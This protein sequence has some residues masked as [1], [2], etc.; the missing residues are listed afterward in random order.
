M[1][2]IMEL[3]FEP[4]L[5]ILP[6]EAKRDLLKFYEFLVFKYLKN[7]DVSKDAAVDENKNLENF[8][9]FKQLRNRLNPRVDKS[10]DIDKLAN[11]VNR[12]IF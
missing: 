1:E 4:K 3:N 9:Q 5:E 2:V 12:D 10:I 7:K 11:E 8:Y 6:D